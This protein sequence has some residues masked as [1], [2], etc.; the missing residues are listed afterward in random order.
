MSIPL[1]FYSLDFAA[2][3]FESIEEFVGHVLACQR[4]IHKLVNAHQ[5]QSR[6]RQML[7]KY[8]KANALKAGDAVWV[9]QKYPKV[10]PANLFALGVDVMKSPVFYR[11]VVCMCRLY[12]EVLKKYVPHIGTGSRCNPLG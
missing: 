3:S 4:E 8:L 9:S 1:S 7:D 5:A 6:Q 11:P 12:F 10:V 2:K